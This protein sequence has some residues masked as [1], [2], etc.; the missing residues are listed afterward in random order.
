[1]ARYVTTK[2]A[3]GAAAGGGGGVGQVDPPLLKY[4]NMH[5]R[6]FVICFVQTL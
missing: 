5:V 6:Q 3:T 1:M 4:V 2:S